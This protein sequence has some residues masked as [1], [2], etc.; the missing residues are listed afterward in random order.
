MNREVNSQN[1]GLWPNSE[2]GSGY[3][4]QEENLQDGRTSPLLLLSTNS[5][6]S[7]KDVSNEQGKSTS[8]K[9]VS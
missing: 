1:I 9:S 7:K 5:L 6:P 4:S 3:G 2:D 8:T